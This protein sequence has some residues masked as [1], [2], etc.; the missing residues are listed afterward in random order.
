MIGRSC[1][2]HR[3]LSQC[4]TLGQ[5]C[6]AKPTVYSSRNQSAEFHSPPT[7]LVRQ[8]VASKPDTVRHNLKFNV[9]DEIER[10]FLNFY[11]DLIHLLGR[12]LSG[13]HPA[14][15][16]KF[17]KLLT[18]SLST[19]VIGKRYGLLVPRSYKEL[20]Q[21]GREEEAVVLGWAVELTRAANNLTA[22]IVHDLEHNRRGHQTWHRKNKM[23]QSALAHVKVLES[24]VY[25]LLRKY[26]E[27]TDH[28]PL[29]I[30]RF[31]AAVENQ[32]TSYSLD[33]KLNPGDR[34][35]NLQAYEMW[36]YKSLV[37]SSKTFPCLVL[38]VSLALHLADLSQPRVHDESKQILTEI[39]LLHQ[40]RQDFENC[41]KHAEEGDI[42]R[43]RITWL[44]CVASQRASA[45][46]LAEL[47]QC[48]GD[49]DSRSIA[50]V[51]QIYYELKLNRNIPIYLD[52]K[53]ADIEGAIQRM[54]KVDRVG[55]SQSLFFKILGDITSDD[56]TFI[57]S[58]GHYQL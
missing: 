55:L 2:L 29:C 20:G 16:T 44:I 46:Q 47:D 14:L 36:R 26:F 28:L 7:N 8:G 53:M 56:F 13:Q 54:A 17:T 42:A 4:S 45:K 15:A 11:P 9:R 37:Y 40:I 39:G 51:K 33:L 30:E 31:S 10:K 1:L 22:E 35:P 48:Y 49:S 24:S 21:S 58:P 23:G 12:E 6:C 18:S 52:E 43:G 3:Y 41:F 38:P 19:S 50:R 5:V 34:K 25:I 27:G 57:Q 32:A